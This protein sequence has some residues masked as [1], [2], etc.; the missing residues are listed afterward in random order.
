MGQSA[1]S[2]SDMEQALISGQQAAVDPRQLQAYQDAERSAFYASPERARAA[3]VDPEADAY[4]LNTRSPVTNGERTWVPDSGYKRRTKSQSKLSKYKPGTFGY[5]YDHPK[6]EQ[7]YPDVM[8]TKIKKMS[9]KEEENPQANAYLDPSTGAV[10]VS[11]KNI[12]SNFSE[13]NVDDRIQA[14]MLHEVAGHKAQLAEGEVA[15]ASAEPT[16]EDQ[17]SGSQEGLRRYLLNY[18]ENEADLMEN[19]WMDNKGNDPKYNPG[20]ARRIMSRARRK[21]TGETR[22]VDTPFDFMKDN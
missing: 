21:S 16:I 6:L 14:I 19:L 4:G 22:A 5:D 11:R 7:A 17:I 9:K 15:G 2:M 3:G 1:F 20:S 8:N 13:D 10:H 18:G 12:A